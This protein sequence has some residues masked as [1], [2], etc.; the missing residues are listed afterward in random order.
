MEW[1]VQILCAVNTVSYLRRPFL[2]PRAL[3]RI[4]GVTPPDGSE[5][6]GAT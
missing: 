5:W 1:F 2:K 3:A 6:E 4:V